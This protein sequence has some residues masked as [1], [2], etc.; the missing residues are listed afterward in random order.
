MT[1]LINHTNSCMPSIYGLMKNLWCHIQPRRKIHFVFL[2]LLMILTSVIEIIG[3]GSVIPLLGS[4][5]NPQSLMQNPRLY[6]ILKWLNILTERELIVGLSILFITI[7]LITNVM[8]L[9]LLWSS[10]RLANTISSELGY[11]AYENILYQP[12]EQ[13][14]SRSIGDVVHGILL[15]VS[16]AASQIGMGLILINSTILSLGILVAIIFINPYIAFFTGLVLSFFYFLIGTIVKDRLHK[17]SIKHSN[18]SQSVMNSVIEGLGGIRDVLLDGLQKTYAQSFIKKDYL[19]KRALGNVQILGAAPRFIIETIGVSAIVIAAVALSLALRDPLKTIPLLGATAL[20]ALRLLPIIQNGF[21]A[22]SNLQ[23]NKTALNDALA[24]LNYPA[25]IHKPQGAD[26]I[27]KFDKTIRFS[28][29]DYQ[30]PDQD[31]EALISINYEIKK[32]D[33]VGLIGKTASGK[34]TFMD[35]F[36]ALLKPT[37]GGIYVDDVLLTNDNSWEWQR[38]LAHVPQVIFLTDTSIAENIAFGIPKENIDM[39]RV[40][41]AANIAQLTQDFDNLSMRVGERGVRLSGG[42]RQRI[43]IA[44]AIYKN[45]STYIFDEATSALD[46]ET[47]SNVMNAIE[48]WAKDN[49]KKLTIIFIA[50]RKSTLKNCD[51]I[52]EL[53]NGRIKRV[54]TYQDIIRG[55]G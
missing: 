21:Y 20:G 16:I 24:F 45:A 13:H 37:S 18:Y 7:T 11:L 27:L 1:I 14:I 3:I 51:Q 33:R 17:N 40:L 12:Y 52:L 25:T 54:G 47:E 34:S 43:G 4:I 55:A 41:V 22:W 44:R 5:I 42:Q 39:E 31:K 50:H 23:G 53:D 30:Y 28:N 10:T 26:Q 6:S 38:Q 19:S 2:L 46:T 49:N 8:R 48:N 36:M 29:V 15:N 32:G 35:I 9:L